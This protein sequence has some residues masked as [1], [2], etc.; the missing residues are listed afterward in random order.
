VKGTPQAELANQAANRL[1]AFV[2]KLLPYADDS[3]VVEF[4][5][6][7]ADQYRSLQRQD[8][9]TCYKFAA[10]S[11]DGAAIALIPVELTDRERTLD[12]RV[13]SS[14][15]VRASAAADDSS[16]D[17]IRAGLAERGYS[18]SELKLLDAETV[19][20]SDYARYCD[21]SISLFQEIAKLPS[22]EAASVFRE[23]FSKS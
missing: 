20:P 21:L 17:K 19:A 5:Q 18:G 16:W 7:A 15:K 12:A 1:G 8:E 13:I 11:D 3:V 14:A 22:K 9:T 10:G 4:G 2:R 6:L 23:I